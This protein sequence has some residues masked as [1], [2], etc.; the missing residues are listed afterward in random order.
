MITTIHREEE[1][2][3]IVHHTVISPVRQIAGVL[4]RLTAGAGLLFGRIGRM[5]GRRRDG[6]PED[7][8]FI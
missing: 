3:D 6:G 1:T 4:Q 5:R 2:T 8:M 7:E